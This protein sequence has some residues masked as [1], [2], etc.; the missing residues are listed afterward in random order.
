M[1]IETTIDTF[2]NITFDQSNKNY[3]KINLDAL[4]QWWDDL[5]LG[6]FLEPWFEENSTDTIGD[7]ANKIKN[8]IYTERL[9][10]AKNTHQGKNTSDDDK[11]VNKYGVAYSCD[12]YPNI[13][14]SE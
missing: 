8:K 11:F 1:T 5:N 6:L 7:Y 13:F 3:Q 9:K 2:G 12:F 4:P 14:I 10:K